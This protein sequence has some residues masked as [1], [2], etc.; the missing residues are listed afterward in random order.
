MRSFPA[1]GRRIL[2]AISTR[3]VYTV[4]GSGS[5]AEAPTHRTSAKALVT[6]AAVVAFG[7]MLIPGGHA[8][9]AQAQPAAL[10]ESP[11]VAA[12]V[13][14]GDLQLSAPEHQDDTTGPMAVVAANL[15]QLANPAD[16][17]ADEHAAD[18]HP[19][20]EQAPDEHRDQP[21]QDEQPAEQAAPAEQ[22]EPAPA[23]A[24]EPEPVQVPVKLE[25][26]SPAPGAPISN[27]YHKTNASYAAG[28][29]TGTDFAVSVG[30]PLLAVG[31]STVVSS[32][33][34]G[35]YGNQV[36]LKLSDG[37]FAQYAHLSQLDVKA[38]QH[39]NAG[40][41]IGKSGNTGNSTGPHLH[42]EI[43]TANQY[44]KV[45]DPIAY[46]KGHGANNF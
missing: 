30:T 24:P 34:A 35:A 37:R 46:L 44:A 11:F 3:H 22:S 2:Q 7:A 23:P 4:T 38:G 45:T 29:H 41:R 33:W 19:A 31:N 40:D 25:W 5:A 17:H 8:V 21:Q 13:Q 12:D 16:E 6:G 27:P 26:S 28:Y 10:G 39:V 32:G 20:D 18:E 1:T 15:E 43:R 9:A 42:F 36:V 14:P